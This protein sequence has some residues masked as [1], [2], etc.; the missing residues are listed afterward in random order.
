MNYNFDL[1]L[2]IPYKNSAQKIR[3]MSEHWVG[4]NIFCPCCGNARLTA[5]PNNAPVADFQCNNCGE[6]FELKSKKGNISKKIPDGAY[7]TM[8]NRVTS[9]TNPHLF[10]L[11]YSNDLSVQSLSV[12]PKFF[13][14]PQVIE[15]RKPLVETA[16]RAGWTGCNILFSKIPLQGRIEIIKQENFYDKNEIVHQYQ[17]IRKLQT[18]N[19]EQR[20]WLFDTLNC[21]NSISSN[22]FSLCQIYSFIPVLQVLHPD[23]N[24]VEAK[25]RQQ[26][27]ILRNKGFIEFLGNGQYKKI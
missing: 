27:Q 10:V 22:E 4:K 26:L 24:N 14:T 19:I 15:K 1:S 6:I 7:D 5:Q 18:N 11:S 16:R 3:I 12:I 17:K 20:G 9:S 25:L 23:N 21:I 2:A 13:F 8:I